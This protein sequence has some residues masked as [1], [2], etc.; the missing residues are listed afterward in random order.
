LQGPLGATGLPGALGHGQRLGKVPAAAEVATAVSELRAHG[1]TRA[2]G[3]P[4]P[5]V[6][7]F[8]APVWSHEGQVALVI[9]LLGHQDHVPSA[10]KSPGALALR[11]A[12]SQLSRSLGA[13]SKEPT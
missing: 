4:I 12:A 10:W 7:A 5:G 8:S 11:Q 3:R 1:V 6:N 13:A 9:T 2:V